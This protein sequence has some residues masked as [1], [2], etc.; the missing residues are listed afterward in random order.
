[1]TDIKKLK[2]EIR[3][4]IKWSQ[5]RP[6]QTGGQSCGMTQYPIIL[7]SEALELEITYGRHNSSLKNKEQAYLLFELLLD[8]EIR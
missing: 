4:E 7:T 1:M 8:E 6:N 3:K 2:E 5:K